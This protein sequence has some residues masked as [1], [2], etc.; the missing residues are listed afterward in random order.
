[1]LAYEPPAGM[2]GARQA[3]SAWYATR[4]HSVAPE[5]LLLTAS[6]SEAYAYLF[7][8]LTDPGD[9]VLVPSPSYPLFEFLANMESVSV[10]P[11]PLEYHGE[12]RIDVP[13]LA[14]AITD[15]TH[16]IILLNPTSPNGHDAKRGAARHRTLRRRYRLVMTSSPTTFLPMIPNAS[17]FRRRRRVPGLS[18]SGL[19][20][21]RPAADETRLDRRRCPRRCA[22][23]RSK[24]WS[25]LPTRTFR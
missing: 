12:W 25:G 5:H 19:P 13:A 23:K 15:K 21:G 20:G 8:L 18:M 4:G 9:Q 24:S 14:E 22:M 10:R 16:D 7:K 3:V 1:M 17:P 6:T 11:Y 2:P